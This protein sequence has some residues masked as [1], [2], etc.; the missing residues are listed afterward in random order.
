MKNLRKYKY[1][2]TKP[3]S[4]IVKDLLSGLL[5][6]GAVIVAANSPYFIPYV[7]KRYEKLKKYPKRKVSDAF[8]RLRKQGFIEIQ[9]VNHQIYI[10]LTTEGKKR[11]GIFQI[12]KLKITRPKKWDR[13]WRL[14]MF[15]IPQERKIY[16][17]ALRGKL[18]ELGFLPFQKSVWAFPFE[19]RGEMELL[20]NF[21]GLSNNEMRLIT[22]ENIRD[23]SKLQ[24]D[25]K[26]I[27]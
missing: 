14:L 7:I 2:F 5:V 6:V 21:F 18:K 22:A 27:A 17:E 10:S 20:Q 16:R 13:K 12:D 23:D 19:C 3:K 8:Y 11:A 15:D 1:Y 26:L 25:F 9:T 24:Q 4:E